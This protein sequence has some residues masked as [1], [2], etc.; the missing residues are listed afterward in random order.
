M[1]FAGVAQLLFFS[2]CSVAS[3]PLTINSVFEIAAEVL[4]QWKMFT[5]YSE[6]AFTQ[7]N[8]V[9]VKNLLM[10]GIFSRS[11]GKNITCGP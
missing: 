10:N 6:S 1:A 3:I 7:Q 2:P 4:S 9:L 8:L 11:D 5:L